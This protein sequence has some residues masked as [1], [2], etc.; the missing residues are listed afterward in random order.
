MLVCITDQDMFD[1]TETI[2]QGT[3]SIVHHSDA[4]VRTFVTKTCRDIIDDVEKLYD[5]QD[6]CVHF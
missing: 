4:F 3:P 1:M 5:I 2:I 6:D